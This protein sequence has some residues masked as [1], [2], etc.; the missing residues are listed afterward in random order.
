MKKK[1]LAIFL[2]L[3]MVF[4]MGTPGIA[5]AET[6]GETESTADEPV[7]AVSFTS[8]TKVFTDVGPLLPAVLVDS[9]TRAFRAAKKAADNA[10]S[11]GGIKLSKKV[12]PNGKG[13]YTVTLESYT[14]GTVVTSTSTAPVDIVLVLDQSGSMAYD[15]KGNPTSTNADRRQYAM[16][17]AVNSFIDAVNQKYSAEGDH[18]MAIVTFG[19]DAKTLQDWTYVDDMGKS[20]LQEKVSG[21][22]TSPSG[23]TN[24]G[25]GMETAETLMGS[26]Y[27]YT[28]KNTTRQKVVITFTDGVPTTS[29]RF[30]VDVANTALTAAKHMKDAGVTI[31]SVGIF[32]GADPSQLYGDCDGNVGD[33]WGQ[34]S[35]L[36]SGD[37]AVVDQPAG[38]RFLNYVSSNFADATEIGLKSADWS[39]FIARYQGWEITKNFERTTTNNYYLTANDEASLNEIFTN[40][41]HQIGVPSVELGTETVVQ[42]VISDY[43]QLPPNATTSD[44][45][46]YTADATAKALGTPNA[47]DAWKDRVQSN[48][49]PTIDGRTVSVTGFDFTKNFVADKGSTEDDRNKSGDF[50]GRKLI[51][52]FTIEP[53]TGFLGG[54]AVPTNGADSGIYDKDGKK[55]GTFTADPETQDV[56]IKPI[57]VEV[58]DV[59]TYLTNSVTADD[60][61]KHSTVKCGDVTLDLTQPNYGLA[62][63]QT[64]YVSIYVGLTPENGEQNLTQDKTYSLSVSVSPS[65][66]MGSVIPKTGDDNGTISVLF[67]RTAYQDTQIALGETANYANNRVTT[68]LSWVDKDGKDHTNDSSMIVIGEAPTL[69]FTYSPVEDAFTT[70]TPVYVT[71]KIDNLDVTS[72]V[73]FYRAKCDFDGCNWNA[74]GRVTS[75]DPNFIVHVKS[76]DLTITK[77]VDAVEPNQ[78]FLFHI[79]KDNA[80]YMDV[81]VQVGA[82]KTGSVTI[83]G[84]PVGSYTVTEDTAWSWR[85]ALQGDNDRAVDLNS[86]VNGVVTIDFVNKLDKHTW[87]S[88]ETSCENRWSGNQILKNGRPLSK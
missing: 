69:T 39:I 77:T 21:L 85:Y 72:Y 20:A 79:K 10:E 53:R 41:S 14:T 11:T 57:T 22:P 8:E 38:N 63:W 75:G 44:I 60:L 15:F 2:C 59:Y 88:G 36:F 16:K 47:A 46:V 83:K 54:N 56:E 25:A 26:G 19:S 45:K 43:F 87:L 29:T 76:F 27:N 42:D 86:G 70:D 12:T 62:D 6:S 82:D 37:T 80:D 71:A 50:Y 33:K 55:V 34:T 65:N 4:A 74:V 18:R 58:D 35:I 52:E 28:G 24:I 49:V 78:T 67:P 30:D 84:L 73:W 68:A 3:L 32:S 5:V 40:I 48:L 1:L 23:A 61:K 9:T 81:T 17:Q 64:K 13:G 51:V 7:Q 66:T 31:Y